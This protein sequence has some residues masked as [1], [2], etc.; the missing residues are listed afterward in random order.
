MLISI[1]SLLT[2][3]VCGVVFSFFKLPIPAPGA[4]NGILGII[5]IWVGYM[6]IKLILK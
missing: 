2:G 1:L 4:F 6:V 3:F 5:G